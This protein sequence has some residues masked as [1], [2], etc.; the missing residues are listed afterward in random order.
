M[1]LLFA[2]PVVSSADAHVLD[3]TTARYYATG[4]YGDNDVAAEIRSGVDPGS[5]S[6][7]W[8]GSC[9]RPWGSATYQDHRV[10]LEIVFP[11]H[12]HPQGVRSRVWV[13][14]RDGGIVDNPNYIGPPAGW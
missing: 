12:N 7:W 10:I 14:F 8:W 6:S 13:M 4:F 1:A 3:C 11:T 2:S 5:T 9:D